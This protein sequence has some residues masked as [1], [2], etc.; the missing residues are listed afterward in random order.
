MMS[1]Y[2]NVLSDLRQSLDLLITSS[3]G[4]WREVRRREVSLPTSIRDTQYSEVV[5][6]LVRVLDASFDL[7]RR[8][9][10]FMGTIPDDDDLFLSHHL[11]EIRNFQ[12]DRRMLETRHRRNQDIFILM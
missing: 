3:Y 8:I 5:D 12:I 1:R 10:L 7:N 4:F 6:E 9:L 2:R 11:D